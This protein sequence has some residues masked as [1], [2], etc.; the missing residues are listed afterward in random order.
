[1]KN[2]LTTSVAIMIFSVITLSE[3]LFAQDT[4]RPATA[5]VVSSPDDR[6]PDGQLWSSAEPKEFSDLNHYHS[7]AESK[8]L[9]HPETLLQFIIAPETSYT[10]RLAAVFHGAKTIPVTQMPIV[11]EDRDELSEQD[12]KYG[13]GMLEN[14]QNQLL[15]I[16]E[17][18]PPTLN[19]L[20]HIWRAPAT[21]LPYPQTWREESHAPW[22]W[23]VEQALEN[24]FDRM[25]P[26]SNE[27]L[28]GGV[29]AAERWF[30]VA[31]TMPC[32]NQAQ[33]I[34]FVEAVQQINYVRWP[35]PVMF[36]LR[37]IAADPSMP[38]GAAYVAIAIGRCARMEN[39][40][41]RGLTQLIFLALL[42]Q[43]KDKDRLILNADL[44]AFRAESPP[45]FKRSPLPATTILE[46]CKLAVDPQSAP[47]IDRLYCFAFPVCQTVDNPPLAPV[48][49]LDPR[50]PEVQK[51]LKKFSDWFD[52]NKS[53]LEAA[54]KAESP[55]LERLRAESDEA[56]RWAAPTTAP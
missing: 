27:Y 35:L 11:L 4:T 33:A 9:A 28:D 26:V 21:R 49:G 19:V 23:Q 46:V 52:K 6:A 45:A 8:A 10:D 25:A 31:M 34:C 50:A 43:P 13:W 2:I 3:P 40:R 5:Q 55:A 15:E 47:D 54:S 22:P 12:R 7:T 17:D 41:D 36:R 18:P 14:P 37:Q 44:S 39:D 51:D 24:L 48:L 53:A 20:G 29:A 30:D 42:K 38:Q 16:Y 1:M 56:A 32:D